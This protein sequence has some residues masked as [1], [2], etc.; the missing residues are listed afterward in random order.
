MPVQLPFETPA[1]LACGGELKNTFAIAREDRVILSQHIGDLTNAETYAFFQEMVDRFEH[2]FRHHPR[3]LAHDLHPQYL[4]T[5]YARERSSSADPNLETLAVQHHHAHVAACMAD[6]GVV[7]PVIGV[8]FDG[9]GYGLDG[10]VWGAEL[11]VADYG[12][13]RR[14]GQ[15][16]YVPL[17]GGDQASRQ[18]WR[19]A[20]SYLYDLSGGRLDPWPRSLME[21]FESA[22]IDA[23][24][25][26][27]ERK[28]N[29]PLA[30][31]M[32]RLFDAVAALVGLCDENTFEGQAA[33]SL[34]VA[35]GSAAGPLVG[36]PWALQEQ[37][38]FITV[39]AKPL[40]SGVLADLRRGV[41]KEQI[42]WR[43]HRSVAE[44]V[45]SCAGRIRQLFGLNRVALSGG[46]FQ[47][48]LLTEMTLELLRTA[49]FEPLV[50]RRVPPND[51]GLSLGQAA[52]AGWKM[53]G[54]ASCV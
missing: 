40:F 39:D 5:R 26:M 53:S 20:L 43:F 28:F 36:Y 22:Q 30:S 2:L 31:S 14:Q 46:V 7:E 29:S 49:H 25:D 48:K 34:E 23:V 21:R 47:N 15:L 24:V 9:L 27:L 41:P 17:P 6:N 13:F 3:L 8:V 44:L 45:A 12:G 38:S 51:G 16:R 18:P 52:I 54:R 10:H 11:L 42:A 37:K 35:A 1:L 4:S 33:V 19:M 32:G 50:H